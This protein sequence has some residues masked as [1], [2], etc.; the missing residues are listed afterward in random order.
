M[1]LTVRMSPE[2]CPSPPAVSMTL[3]QLKMADALL[4]ASPP[5]RTSLDST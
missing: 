4:D 2:G 1:T 3:C 5:S